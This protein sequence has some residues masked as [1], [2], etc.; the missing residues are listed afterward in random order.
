VRDLT[1]ASRVLKPALRS[2]AQALRAGVPALRRTSRLS[3]DLDTTFRALAPLVDDPSVGGALRK[4]RELVI[5]SLE[6]LRPIAEAQLQCNSLGLYGETMGSL[7]S[8]VGVGD[9]PSMPTALVTTLGA[10]NEIFQNSHPS[11]NLGYNPE[12]HADANECE[13]GNEPW[14]GKQS[15]GNPAGYQS[16]TTR[17]S[18]PPPGVRD[19][20]RRAGLLQEEPPR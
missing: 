18:V 2:T 17:T 20:A 14:T 13:S 6:S 5:P 9:G 10:Q 11:S 4:L 15:L 3:H 19:L 1:P 16:K 7:W 12:P 8:G